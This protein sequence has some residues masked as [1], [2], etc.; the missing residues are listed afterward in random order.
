MATKGVPPLPLWV[1][2]FKRRQA[3]GQIGWRNQVNTWDLTPYNSLSFEDSD[4]V[5][6]VYRCST[7]GG[8]GCVDEKGE[9][10]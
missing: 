3:L 9:G 1:E 10:L 5:K 8:S 6:P 7:C 2:E 4:T